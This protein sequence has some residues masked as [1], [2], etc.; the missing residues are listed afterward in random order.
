MEQDIYALIGIRIYSSLVKIP[1]KYDYWNKSSFYYSPL[2]SDA[3][4]KNYYKMLNCSLH[5][6]SI[7]IDKE[8]DEY[9]PRNKL[10]TFIEKINNICNSL[11]IP[12]R[13]L[14]IDET[15]VFSKGII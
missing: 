1:R 2:I 4:S 12:D 8:S 10:G 3:M 14:T 11:Y 6:S 9:A 13:N 7:D 5:L 15:I